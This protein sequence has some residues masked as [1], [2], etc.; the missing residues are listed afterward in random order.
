M[1]GL[2]AEGYIRFV[3]SANGIDVVVDTVVVIAIQEECSLG[4]RG[5]E[6]A[7]DI[8]FVLIWTI[9]KVSRHARRQTHPE[10]G[11]AGC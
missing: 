11:P 3:E 1:S 6:S 5:I 4:A 2:Y 7:S 10:Q 8:V 9:C